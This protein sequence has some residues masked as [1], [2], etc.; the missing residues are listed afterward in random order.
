VD[1][2]LAVKEVANDGAEKPERKRRTLAELLA[3]AATRPTLDAEEVAAGLGI[4][5]STAYRLIST[6]TI[7]AFRI[8][9]TAVIRVRRAVLDETLRKWERGGRRNGRAGR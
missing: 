8:P 1:P 4:G 2:D 5:V 9:G 7:P 6:G 3:A